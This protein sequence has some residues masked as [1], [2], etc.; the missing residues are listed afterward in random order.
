MQKPLTPE[1][2][3]ASTWPCPA[4]SRRS[5]SPPSRRSPSRSAWPGTTAAGSG[6]PRRWTIPTSCSRRAKGRDR[7]TIVE[8]TDGDGKADK[9]TVFADKLSIPTSLALRQRRPDRRA[10]PRHALPEGHR[11]RR[12]GRRAQG[13]VH[14]LGHRRHPRRPE[15]PAL[16]ARQ[17]DLRHRRLLRLRRHGRRRAA[18]RSA[19][20][21]SAS[22]PT[23]RSWS[24]S[25]A[26]TTTPGA[27]AS[28]KRA[29][30]SARRPTAARASTCRS[31]T[32]TTSRS[33]AGR[34]RC[35][36][37]IADSNR[38][39]PDHREGAP[40]RLARRLH[41]RRRA[42][43]VHGPHLPKQ[44][45]N[46][47]AFV[48][49]PTGHLVATFIAPTATAAISARTTPGICVASDD[50]WTAPIMAEVG[51]DGNVWVIDWYNYI[52]QHNPT[53]ER[54]QDRQ[55]RRLRDAAAR[56]DPRP[57]LSHRREGRQA[58]RAA[59]AV[60]RTTR[61]DSSPR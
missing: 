7:I 47:T 27:S 46:R 55:G 30:S 48:A 40:G 36:A 41:R 49:E 24:S 13:P 9:F 12:Q 37:N 25:A 19:R 33:A 32:A 15:Q 2:S 54:V 34:R 61:P 42:T 52:V 44:Y 31:R 21:S 10:G 16:W 8:D 22:S 59:E 28:A 5:C 58:E 35:C 23:A 20:A 56:Q 11:R 1:E 53:P 57:D 26:R 6:S 17:L 60:R 43:P 39:Y 18:Q 4:G 29:W 45:W 50:E 51:P 38:F 14:R 3:H